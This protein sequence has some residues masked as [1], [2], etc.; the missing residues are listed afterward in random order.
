MTSPKS[1]PSARRPRSGNPQG[2]RQRPHAP[3]LNSNPTRSGPRILDAVHDQHGASWF[4]YGTDTRS[5]WFAMADLVRAQSQVFGRLAEINAPVLTA[6]SITAFKTEIED[7][8]TFG[9]ALVATRP[10][11]L[12]NHFVF[13]DGSVISPKDDGRKVIC[14]FEP[15]IRFRSR[16]TLAEWQK[17][18]D[19]FVQQQVLVHFAVAFALVGPLLRFVARGQLN[20]QVE[21][22]GDQETGKSAIGVLASSIW[23]GDP[24]SDVGGGESLDGT[25]NSFDEVKSFRRDSF[26]FLDEANLVGSSPGHRSGFLQDL[27]FKNSSNRGKRRMGDPSALENASL[28]ILSTTNIPLK[29]LVTR[30]NASIR[31]MRSRLITITLAPGRP[32]GVLDT[33]PTGYA[34][35]EA[36]IEALQSAADECW[37]TPARRFVGKLVQR[38]NRDEDRLRRRVAR[39]I[40]RARQALADVPCST[41]VKKTL[42]L[43]AVAGSL[44]SEWDVFPEAW[45]SPTAMIRAIVRLMQD[46][47]PGVS[48]SPIESVRAFAERHQDGIVD[49]TNKKPMSK[50]D[51]DNC[52]GFL[53][54][55]KQLTELL[56]PTVRFQNEFPDYKMILDALESDG[57]LKPENGE[58]KKRSVKAPRGICAG[59]RVYCIRIT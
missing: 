28:A 22:V 40:V 5:I 8:T 21:I 24:N 35:A 42:A 38:A 46:D 15:D 43:V 41:R 59:K 18:F 32:F 45:G 29:D 51:F 52:P 39:D 54:N 17:L 4:R 27:I 53:R 10:G 47:Q 3:R 57:L 58:Q 48:A 26:A 50:G 19:P 7:H 49:L 9:E 25:F 33:V 34:S 14:T 23:A 13:G 20:P 2:R 37:G 30:E 44:A 12:K 11:W 31:A 6:R 56:I 1:K 36:A 16:G 55:Q